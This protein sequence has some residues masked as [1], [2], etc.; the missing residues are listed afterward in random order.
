MLSK[1]ILDVAPASPI[2]VAP[3]TSEPTTSDAQLSDELAQVLRSA[4]SLVNAP[5]SN[6]LS[7]DPDNIKQGLGQLVLTLVKLLHELLERQALRRIE[8]GQLTD[9]QVEDVGYTLMRQSQEITRMAHEFGVKESDLN[10]DLG[11]IGRLF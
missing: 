11:P 4:Q 10:L 6:R 1:P 8:G 9:K 2:A 7:L 5:K 3:N